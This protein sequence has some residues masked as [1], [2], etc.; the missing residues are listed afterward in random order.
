[1]EEG[2][3]SV[4][5]VYKTEDKVRIRADVYRITKNYHEIKLRG[6]AASVE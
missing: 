1:M 4:D 2:C 3:R 5:R 6:A